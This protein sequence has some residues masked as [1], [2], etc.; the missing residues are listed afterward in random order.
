M[1]RSS[2]LSSPNP[3][4][5]L[6]SQRRFVRVWVDRSGGVEL[7][8]INVSVLCMWWSPSVEKACAFVLSPR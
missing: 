2:T 4:A 5:S 7:N 3:T 6:L 1:P 8:F